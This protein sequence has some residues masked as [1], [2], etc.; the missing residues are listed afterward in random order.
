M[1]SADH[2][3]GPPGGR[4]WLTT[5]GW[6]GERPSQTCIQT[7]ECLE[8]SKRRFLDMI[9]L[10]EVQSDNPAHLHNTK[11]KGKEIQKLH[12]KGG[13]KE[14]PVVCEIAGCIWW[15]TVG[16]QPTLCGCPKLPLCKFFFFPPSHIF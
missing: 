11:N 8:A 13:S 6:H 14:R 12:K 15:V 9:F 4:L 10:K 1:P 16:C 5:G 3:P 7:R 2:L